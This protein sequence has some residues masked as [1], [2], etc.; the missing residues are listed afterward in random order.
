MSDLS[1]GK[2][3]LVRLMARGWWLFALRG[4]TAVLF[5]LLAFLVPG[6]G[7]AIMLAFLA[8]WLAIEGASTLWQ[9]IKGPPE[10]HGFWFWVDGLVSLAAAAFLLL[11]PLASAVGLVIVTGAWAMAV[12]V[13]RL[14]LA[15]RLSSVLMGLLGAVT[16]FFGAWLIA[17]PGP[18]LLALIWL[19]GIQALAMG[20]VLL[21]LAWRLRRITQDPHAHV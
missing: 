14:I 1:P 10:R 4:A 15:F 3:H 8:A 7:L 16:V 17:A 5:G 11:A 18:G 13:I 2:I 21:A 9:A 19:V 6:A 20:A 12:G